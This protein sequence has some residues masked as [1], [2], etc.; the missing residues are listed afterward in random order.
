MADLGSFSNSVGT[1]V[2]DFASK[3]LPG[4]TAP[5]GTD[6]LKLLVNGKSFE[7]WQSIQ[8]KRS[9]KAIS[10]SFSLAVVDKWAEEKV[11]WQLSPGDACKVLIGRDTVITGYLD[12]VG[13]HFDAVSRGL[14]VSGRD[15]AGDLVD[16]SIDG[17][18]AQWV[19]LSMLQ[20]AQKL[21]APF[22]IKVRSLTSAGSPGYKWTLQPGE[23]VFEN[24]E[25]A[26]RLCGVLLVNDGLGGIVLTRAGAAHA[27]TELVQGQNLIGGSAEYGMKER[28]SIVTV[29]AQSA[30]LD[31]VDPAVDFTPK[32][33]AT[34]AGVTR[35]RPMVITAE[36]AATAAICRQRARW[37][38]AVRRAKSS[39]VRVK[40]L[41]WR[42][43]DGRLWTVNEL[44]KVTS[45]WLGIK[46]E[47]MIS[48]VTFSKSDAG[49]T[50]ELMLEMAQAY[51]PDPTYLAKKDPWHQ[52]VVQE[53]KR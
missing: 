25:K 48:E 9:I 47:M 5:N 14:A 1:A 24:M 16:C 7:G 13:P 49:T 53:S 20:I 23:S 36:G 50:T 34:D 10:G 4:G 12:S 31:E 2:G 52:L 27:S 37:E 33:T 17:Q 28:H 43:S 29:K 45:P 22:G 26:S 40:V 39:Q 6:T 18:P 30:G 3:L 15:K 19:N 44:V 35:Y 8:V 46:V 11:A 41:G 32:G 21:A 42:Q 38:V 51:T